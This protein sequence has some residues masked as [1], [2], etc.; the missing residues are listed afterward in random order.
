LASF[1][2]QNLDE[3]VSEW[4]AFAR[5]IDP[6]MDTLALR[7]HARPMLEA[8]AADI[9][10]AQS[11]KEQAQKSKGQ[12]ANGAAGGAAAAIHGALRHTVG[13]DLTQLVSEFRAL[14]ATVLRLWVAKEGYG[15]AESAYEM[16]RFNEAIDEALAESVVSYSKELSKSRDTFLAMLGHDLRSPLG[17]IAG[18][19]SVLTSSA[20]P[21][22]H[23]KASAAGT[24][25]VATMES[26][27]RDLLDYTR[28]RLGKGIPVKPAPGDLGEVCRIAVGELALNYP[29]T[30]FRLD[31]QGTLQGVFDTERIRQVVSNLLNNAVQH[32]KAGRPISLLAS[33]SGDTL[34]LEVINEGPGIPDEH[35][36][37]IFEPLVQGEAGIAASKASTNLGLGLYIAREIVTAHGGS[38]EASSSPQGPTRFSVRLPRKARVASGVEA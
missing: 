37:A 7:D 3:I 21:E 29:K 27:I 2:L 22:V 18:A 5:T 34:A 38:I 6:T 25:S 10:T 4:E 33:G 1:I 26:M 32:G 36:Q 13:F 23:A 14:R 28:T 30:G 9:K 31:S 35:L 20:S 19:L 8:I 17:A 15:D 24:R 11:K 12:Q 16:A